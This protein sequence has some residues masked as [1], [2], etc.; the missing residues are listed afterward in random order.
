MNTVDDLQIALM[1]LLDSIGK[2]RAEQKKDSIHIIRK[3]AFIGIHPK[4]SYLG[5]N[6]VLDRSKAVPSASK[7]EQ[8]SA[9]RFHHFY[10]VTDK[11]E[12]NR[13]FA[14]LL[15]EAFDLAQPKK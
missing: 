9:N 5:V 4:K 6:V 12:L 2:Y 14:R 7:V 1:Q 11:R 13:S 3:R 8:I 15:K 10:K